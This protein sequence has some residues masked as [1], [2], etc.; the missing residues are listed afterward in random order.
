[1]ISNPMRYLLL[2]LLV[3]LALLPACGTD[4][5]SSP[6][7]SSMVGDSLVQLAL[8]SPGATVSPPLRIE[9]VARGTYFFEGSFPVRLEDGDGNELITAPATAAG[10]WMTDNWVGYSAIL[11]F[12]PPKTETGTLILERDN[13]SGLER[14]AHRLRIPIRFRTPSER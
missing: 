8:P 11:E 6:S 3:L 4:A 10:D 12:T 1:M 13:P 14:N 9:G 5:E 7:A 2:P